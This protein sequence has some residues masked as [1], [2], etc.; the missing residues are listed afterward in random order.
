MILSRKFYEE[1]SWLGFLSRLA[2]SFIS[3]FK[4]K[5]KIDAQK[6]KQKLGYPNLVKHNGKVICTSCGICELHCPTDAIELS[7]TNAI[8]LHANPFEGK[9]PQKFEL[10]IQQ[11]IQCAECINICPVDA[12][13]LNGGY[14]AEEVVQL[15]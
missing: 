2:K 15:S 3:A 6:D 9:A 4:S 13:Q 14:S 5:V 11:C 12:L 1:H 10:K 7:L 8:D